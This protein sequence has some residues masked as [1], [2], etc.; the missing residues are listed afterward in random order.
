M[1]NILIIALPRSGGT[2]LMEST[3][4]ENDLPS[5]FEPEL[6]SSKI[7]PKNDV[8][9]I[10]VD[11]FNLGDIYDLCLYY[12]KIILHS[13]RDS[14]ACAESLAYMHWFSGMNGQAL[15]PWNDG[16]LNNIPKW[17][18]EQTKHRINN[19][20]NLLIKISNKLSI[21]IQYYEDIFDTCSTQRLRKNIK[22]SII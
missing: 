11:R 13:R 14:I 2:A 20:K 8:T 17:Y 4:A 1:K 3:A 5:R 12:E 6:Q 15:T 16:M 21:P 22:S 19:C 18:I 9:K 7:E 10:I